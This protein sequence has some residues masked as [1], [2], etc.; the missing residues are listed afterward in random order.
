MIVRTQWRAGLKVTGRWGSADPNLQNVPKKMRGIFKARKDKYFVEAD[1]SQLELRI[2]ALLA[3]D[4]PL[5]AAYAKGLDVHMLNA[6]D[7]FQKKDPSPNERKLAKVF[8]YGVNYGANPKTLHR[9]M[10]PGFPGLTEEVIE[11]LKDRW[12]EVHPD[13]VSWQA[14]QLESAKQH[15]YVECPLSGRRF[16]FYLN[17]VEPT[18]CY[19]FVIQGTAADIM[20]ESI[21][22]VAYKVPLYDAEILVQLHD[23]ILLE[24]KN[25]PGL[26]DL[27][28]KKM[29]KT[30]S[31][32]GNSMDF[33]VD[34]SY[35]K[36]WGEMKEYDDAEF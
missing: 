32:N 16:Y 5:L 9:Q 6:M 18:K 20:N 11:H 12:E 24:G 26:A 4:R 17:M 10:A 14:R 13:I 2:L 15:K 35:G 27:L 22:E 3:Q 36:N 19:N 23:A 33:P 25:V 34:V 30:I 28:E 1:Y 7:L 31:L 21:L 8:V 29:S